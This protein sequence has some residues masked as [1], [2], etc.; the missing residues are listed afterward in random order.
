VNTGAGY[1]LFPIRFHG[2]IT[3]IL[4]FLA[5]ERDSHVSS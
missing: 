2:L 5:Y 4:D 1:F 3:Q